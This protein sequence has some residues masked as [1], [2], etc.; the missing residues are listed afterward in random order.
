MTERF[1]DR[2]GYRPSAAQ[3]AIREDAPS[4][5]RGA[6]PLIASE[7]GMTQFAIR[8]VMCKV[9]LVQ[10][11]VN[12]WSEYPNIRDEVIYLIGDAPWY[13]VYDI[14]QI[15]SLTQPAS[16]TRRSHP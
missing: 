11:D 7:A 6:I 15:D 12:N 3:I 9:L 13:K 8:E 10:P 5:L 1:S 14:G 2:Q 16:A 4:S